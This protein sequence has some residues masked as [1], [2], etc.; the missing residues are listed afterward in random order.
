MK[1]PYSGNNTN[2]AVRSRI[3]DLRVNPSLFCC[4][5]LMQNS[6]V[7]LVPMTNGKGISSG[8]SLQSEMSVI[9]LCCN[10]RIFCLF[11]FSAVRSSAKN[12]EEHLPKHSSSVQLSLYNQVPKIPALGFIH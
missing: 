6:P 12:A 3:L 11:C 9:F 1:F 4:F 10:R 2:K 8:R 5:F 7:T